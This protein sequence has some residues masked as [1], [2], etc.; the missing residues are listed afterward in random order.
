[1]RPVSA[2]EATEDTPQ[3]G[4]VIQGPWPA[5]EDSKPVSFPPPTHSSQARWL[6]EEIT[7]IL[8]YSAVGFVGV[9]V[10]AAIAFSLILAF[11][12][13][14]LQ[15]HTLGFL[16]GFLVAAHGHA[17]FTFTDVDDPPRARRRFFVVCCAAL[18]IS[19]GFAASLT[20]IGVGVLLAQ[21]LTIIVSCCLSYAGSRL[22]AFKS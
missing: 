9:I 16:A 6:L 15:A 2:Q 10:H 4:V 21:G 20:A 18:L 11:E 13:P 1:M 3:M 5:R 14:L 8:N 12:T 17:R 22:W 19:H 7:Q